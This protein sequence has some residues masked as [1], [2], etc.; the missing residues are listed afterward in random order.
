MTNQQNVVF[1]IIEQEN[2]DAGLSITF[3]YD[4]TG[5]EKGKGAYKLSISDESKMYAN[6]VIAARNDMVGAHPFPRYLDDIHPG[7]I[8]TV[9]ARTAFHLAQLAGQRQAEKKPSSGAPSPKP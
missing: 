4:N 1:Q 3:Y 6:E 8:A 2:R 7:V 5:C 9:R